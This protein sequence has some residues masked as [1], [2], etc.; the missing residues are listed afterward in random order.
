MSESTQG[1]WMVM[2]TWPGGR[3][4]NPPAG[5]AYP[6]VGVSE[7][8][9]RATAKGMQARLPAGCSTRYE[10]VEIPRG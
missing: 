9:A 8:E 6:V 3:D 1:A 2:A 10:A 7:A 4:N 5:K